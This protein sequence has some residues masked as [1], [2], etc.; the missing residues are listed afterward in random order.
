[1]NAA[2]EGVAA[3]DQRS[4]PASPTRL[5]ALLHVQPHDVPLLLIGQP[6]AQTTL[7][8]RQLETSTLFRSAIS[9]HVTMPAPVVQPTY[10]SKLPFGSVYQLF[11]LCFTALAIVVV[12]AYACIAI[13][14]P[15]DSKSTLSASFIDADCVADNP[16]LCFRARVESGMTSVK[17]AETARREDCIGQ[18]FQQLFLD[19]SGDDF[20]VD[21][22]EATDM[23]K[24]IHSKLSKYNVC[25]LEPQTYKAKPHECFVHATEHGPMS[26]AECSRFVACLVSHESPQCRAVVCA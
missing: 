25:G 19:Y 16:L 23:A 18:H 24:N 22:H 8:R 26:K 17:A 10:H 11:L 7:D 12:V 14:A 2:I 21:M 6:P 15:L 13:Y 5:R 20:R 9:P 3:I 1:M 4:R